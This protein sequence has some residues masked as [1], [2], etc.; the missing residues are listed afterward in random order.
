M[1]LQKFF[2]TESRQTRIT[3]MGKIGFSRKVSE[4]FDAKAQ[5]KSVNSS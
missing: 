5:R 2:W 1:E 4:S 3:E